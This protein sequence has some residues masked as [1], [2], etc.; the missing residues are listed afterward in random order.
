MVS[1]STSYNDAQIIELWLGRQ[2]SPLT[3]DCYQRDVDR[4]LAYTC[5]PLCHIALGDLQGFA[6]SLVVAGLAPVSRARTLAAIKSLLGFCQRMLYIATNPAAELLLPGYENRLAERIVPEDEVARML[7]TE[8]TERDSLLLRLLYGAGL[9]VSELCGLRWR[10]LRQHGNAGQ[11]AVFGKGGKTRSITLPAPL[12]T[13]LY[14]FRN[15]AGAELPVFSSRSGRPLDRG[16]VRI[17]VRTAAQ[18]AGL[19]EQV[20]PHWLR[21]AHASHALDHGAPIHLV[22]AT[23]GHSSVATTSAYLHARPG[24]SSSRFLSAETFLPKSGGVALPSERAGVMDVMTAAPT[25]EG[26]QTEMKHFTIDAEN[27]ITAHA[28]RKDAREAGAPTFSTE[29]QFADAIGNDSQRLVEI[30]NSLPGVKPVT[31]FTNR[32]VATERI[33]KAIAQLGGPR[34]AEAQP[35]P[36]ATESQ[37]SGESAVVSGEGRPSPAPTAEPLATAGGGVPAAAPQKPRVAPAKG[38]ASKKATPPKKAPKS[39]K[40]AKPAAK[41]AGA[42][43]GSKTA[44]VLDLVTRAGGATLKEIMK[45]TGWQ[46]HSVRGFISGALGKKMGLTVESFK[47]A[48][49]ERAYRI[50]K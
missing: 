35:I 42:R 49:D 9:R 47:N 39:A 46:P 27:N 20:S 38:K 48:T 17:I 16:R 41:T 31:R 12:M 1:R 3:R 50:A 6:Q 24:D 26:D 15:G 18:A 28:S 45:A 10:N 33:W 32:K 36:E 8:A 11:I 14:R 19:D 5:K 25:A 2:A 23:L 21:H 30:W 4:L 7:A 29:E 43:E 22:Q 13:D 44:K 37:A 40:A 34:V